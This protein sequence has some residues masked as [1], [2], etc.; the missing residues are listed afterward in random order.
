MTNPLY[1]PNLCMYPRGNFLSVTKGYS[2]ISNP[3][4]D[5]IGSLFGLEE[6]LGVVKVFPSTE[7]DP[8]LKWKQI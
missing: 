4:D 8:V 3:S 1:L 2:I 7:F 5:S 6:A